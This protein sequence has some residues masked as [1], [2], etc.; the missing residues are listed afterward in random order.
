M[1]L[2]E[3]QLIT[4]QEF[5]NKANMDLHFVQ[6]LQEFH[7]GAIKVKSASCL[8]GYQLIPVSKGL[9]NRSQ[10]LKTA[11]CKSALKIRTARKSAGWR[12]T[13]GLKRPCMNFIEEEAA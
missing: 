7:Q 5:G 10:L 13:R 2:F 11:A 1:I 3:K 8:A 9:G 12:C 6:S 4:C